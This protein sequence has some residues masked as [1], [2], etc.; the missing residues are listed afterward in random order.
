MDSKHVFKT[1]YAGLKPGTT[2]APSGLA[3]SDH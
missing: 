1:V 2:Y 3:I